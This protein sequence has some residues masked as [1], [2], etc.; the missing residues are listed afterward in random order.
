MHNAYGRS[1]SNMN[2]LSFRR[3]AD[4]LTNKNHMR[5]VRKH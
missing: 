4:V 2:L 5:Q 1:V 3:V